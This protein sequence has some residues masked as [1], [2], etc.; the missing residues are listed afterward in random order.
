MERVE[1]PFHLL[2]E[3]ALK[4]LIEEFVSR[5]GTDYGQSAY[6]LEAKAA[7]VRKQL[8]AGK[9][10]ILYDPAT[11]GCNIVLKEDLGRK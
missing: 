5:E 9:A 4:A 11:E 6:T 8:E 3:D 2:S 10:V 1:V 7:M